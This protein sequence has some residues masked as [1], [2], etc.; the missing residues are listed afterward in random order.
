VLLHYVATPWQPTI[1]L[2]AGSHY[3]M[4]AAPIGLMTAVAL[5]R[6]GTAAVAGV[7]TAA[8]AAI[9]VPA[10][11]GDGTPTGS[12]LVVLQ[13]NLR[14]GSADPAALVG[15][16]RS[17]QVELLATE[18]L[19]DQA[20]DGLVA[21]GLPELLP[22]RYTAPLLEGGGGLGIWSR[23]PLSTG[24]NLPHFELGVLTARVAVPG[25]P[26][27]FVAAHLLPPYPYPARKWRS[28]IARLR[29]TLAGLRG[30]QPVVVAGDFNATTDHAQF[31]QLLGHGYRDAAGQAGAGYLPTYPTD[32]WYGPVI[33]I[34]HVLLRHATAADART[35]DLPGSDHRALVVNL[36]L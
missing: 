8:V 33:G 14:V 24:R 12:R 21:A 36:G 35:L 30:D 7:L 15:I 20:Q 9:Q 17:R 19:T 22:Y 27:T 28:E 25:R 34:D 11:I 2:T 5:R 18:E 29:W 6:W 16:V 23:Y 1:A 10:N 31:R 26:I 3:L 13:A 4:W 32:R